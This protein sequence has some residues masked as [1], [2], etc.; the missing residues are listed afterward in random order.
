MV[1]HRAAARTFSTC[2]ASRNTGGHRRISTLLTLP[3]LT[4][5]NLFGVCTQ[6][7]CSPTATLGKRRFSSTSAPATPTQRSPA[8]IQGSSDGLNRVRVGAATSGATAPVVR[9]SQQTADTEESDSDHEEEPALSPDARLDPGLYL[10]ATPIGLD[11]RIMSPS[12]PLVH[13]GLTC[14]CLQLS[15]MDVNW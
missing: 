9:S 3:S 8:S 11:Q 5:T 4:A 1:L 12:K 7:H 15:S 10:V 2:A 6:Y 13:S 14:Q